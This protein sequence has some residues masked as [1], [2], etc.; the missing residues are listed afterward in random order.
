[1]RYGAEKSQH[2]SDNLE[3]LKRLRTLIQVVPFAE[4]AGEEYGAIRAFLEK[5]GRLFGSNDLLIAAHAKSM[6]LILVTNNIR[7]FKR[8][9]GL[10]VELWA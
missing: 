9:P 1:L 4:A 10:S 8:V 7:E 5:K 2:R 6:N 3:T